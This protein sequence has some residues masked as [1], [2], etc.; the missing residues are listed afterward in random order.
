MKEGW[1]ERRKKVGEEEK[2]CLLACKKKKSELSDTERGD[3]QSTPHQ[4]WKADKVESN[5]V[6]S[7]ICV[8]GY[9]LIEM[10]YQK[11]KN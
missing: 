10:N 6:P 4:P 5:S 11:N 8:K 3:L 9:W 7:P 1:K 2:E